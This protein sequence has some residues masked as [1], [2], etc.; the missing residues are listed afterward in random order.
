MLL[1]TANDGLLAT[2]G[3]VVGEF[4]E[5][6]KREGLSEL[7]VEREDELRKFLLYFVWSFVLLLLFKKS[8]SIAIF[9]IPEGHFVI[10]EK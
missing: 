10:F 2:G 3:D 9:F 6:D 7:R 8:S 1:V 5:L 4:E